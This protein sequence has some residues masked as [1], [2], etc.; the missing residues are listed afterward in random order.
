[1]AHKI[2]SIEQLSENVF[3]AEIEASLIAQARRP[4]QFVIVGITDDYSER[5]PLTIAGVDRD[6]GT[7][8]LVW[9]RI[10]NSIQNRAA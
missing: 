1:M 2:L 8:R 3:T 4:G 7:I 9:Q 6:K 10:S 5:I